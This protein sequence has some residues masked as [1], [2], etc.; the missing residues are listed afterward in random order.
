MLGA[1]K[2][3]YVALKLGVG[4]T[5]AL[6]VPGNKVPMTYNGVMTEAYA[7]CIEDSTNNMY[8]YVEKPEGVTDNGPDW[9]VVAID[10]DGICDRM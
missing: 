1:I 10:L 4:I 5:G 2:A 7:L 9:M 8:V 3:M 6:A